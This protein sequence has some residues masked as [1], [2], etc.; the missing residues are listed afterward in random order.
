MH[1]LALLDLG[2][3]MTL[4]VFVLSCTRARLCAKAIHTVSRTKKGHPWMPLI[5]L[6]VEAAGIEPASADALPKGLHA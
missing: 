5:R 2:G 4:I 3:Q 1:I 6:M